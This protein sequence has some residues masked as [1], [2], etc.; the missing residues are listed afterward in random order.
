MKKPLIHL[1]IYKTES[2]KVTSYCVNKLGLKNIFELNDKFEGKSYLDKTLKNYLVNKLLSRYLNPNF[3]PS[4]E[5]LIKTD[6]S[7]FFKENKL[8]VLVTEDIVSVMNNNSNDVI[9][10][11]NLDSLKVSL[12]SHDVQILNKL[13]KMELYD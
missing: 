9:I 5:K 7:K 12:Y 8:D 2:S 6:F 13:K 1:S 4:T 3:K 11:V 10:H